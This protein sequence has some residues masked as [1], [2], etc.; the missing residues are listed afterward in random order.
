[1]EHTTVRAGDV[2]DGGLGVFFVG[3]DSATNE[4]VFMDKSGAAVRRHF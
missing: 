4:L 1:V 3:I 2:I